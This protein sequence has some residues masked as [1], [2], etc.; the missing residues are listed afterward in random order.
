MARFKGR[1]VRQQEKDR[2]VQL[3]ELVSDRNVAD[4][5]K[6]TEAT[7]TYQSIWL[8]GERRIFEPYQVSKDLKAGCTDCGS[9]LHITD[10]V[11]KTNCGL[12]FFMY[13]LCECGTMYD[14]GLGEHKTNRF[15]ADLNI[16]GISASSLAKREKEVS[17]SI[18]KVTDKSLDRSL[19]EEKNASFSRK[20]K[21]TSFVIMGRS[22]FHLL[23]P[24][25][26]L[27]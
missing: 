25:L 3:S 23:F 16:P 12:G 24:R 7:D 26:Q 21:L 9:T 5:T 19:E 1:F 18:K 14:T 10:I 6:N 13:I 15:L 8:P 2:R 11:A 22:S 27:I 17:R 20:L 4:H